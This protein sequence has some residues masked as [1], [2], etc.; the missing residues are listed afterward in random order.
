MGGA[1]SYH[2]TAS[3]A[4]YIMMK[5]RVLSLLLITLSSVLAGDGKDT[6]IYDF[7]NPY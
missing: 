7:R 2:M 5:T 3:V 1:H 4:L 6:F